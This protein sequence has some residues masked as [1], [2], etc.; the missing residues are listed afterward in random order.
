M[1]GQLMSVTTRMWE[2]SVEQPRTISGYHCRVLCRVPCLSRPTRTPRCHKLETS[3]RAR[4]NGA[5][6]KEV[7][8]Y[9]VA[10]RFPSAGPLEAQIF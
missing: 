3:V 8:N 6:Q 2:Q 4:H 5:L 7:P 10:N 9:V 1:L